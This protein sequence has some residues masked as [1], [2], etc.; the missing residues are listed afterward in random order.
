[1]SCNP[2]V[3]DLDRCPT[4]DELVPQFMA[5]LPRGRAWPTSPGSTVWKFWRA[6]AAAFADLEARICALR[7]EFFCQ[8]VAET[9]PAWLAEYGLPDACD[10]FP[11]LCAKV[12]AI[13]GARCEYFAAVAARAGWGIRCLYVA[14]VGLGCFQFGCTPVGKTGDR[15]GTLRVQ[16]TLS[17]SPSYGGSTQRTWQ[18]GRSSFGQPFGCGPDL[19]PL[20]CL[21]GRILPAH[22]AVTYEVLQ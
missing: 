3:A 5:L 21:L 18:F 11:D 15:P 6:V 16:V 17:S 10:P 9:R 13:G 19:G 22:V 4:T 2:A 12:A 1:M 14:P 7:A 8:T 20:K